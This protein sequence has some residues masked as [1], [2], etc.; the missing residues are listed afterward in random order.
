MASIIL[1]DLAQPSDYMDRTFPGTRE[2][3]DLALKKSN[4]LYI[5]NLSFYSTEEQIHELFSKCGEIKRIIMGLD[6]IKMTPCGFCFIEYYEHNN[7]L[8]CLRYINGTKLDDR[9][10]RVDLDPGFRE[11]RQFGRGKHGG[12]IRDMFR[13]EFDPGRG[14]WAA[15]AE[16]KV[17][18]PEPHNY[19]AQYNIVG[20]M[21][22]SY[23]SC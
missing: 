4:T 1:R 22:C 17:S 5:G 10:I 15:S 16:E 9:I 12:Q 7:A 21:I 14:G 20:G 23:I 13:T 11:G 6:K 18:R 2:E 8:D 3:W 19:V